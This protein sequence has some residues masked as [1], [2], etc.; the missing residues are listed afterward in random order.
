MRLM[1]WCNNCIYLK[2]DDSIDEDDLDEDD[3]DCYVCHLGIVNAITCS[4]FSDI[5]LRRLEQR[6]EIDEMWKRIQA[7]TTT[8]T[9]TTN[10]F[11][12]AGYFAA[13]TNSIR[14]D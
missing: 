3:D 14:E 7:S 10:P 1:N 4:N 11:R 8:Y 6:K 5:K 12:D 9:I 2:E 13:Y